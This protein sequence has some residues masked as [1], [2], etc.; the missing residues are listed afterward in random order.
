[1]TFQFGTLA[2]EESFMFAFL[3]FTL[4]FHLKPRKTYPN[5]SEISGFL[6]VVGRHRSGPFTFE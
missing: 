1:M 5:T 3:T 6:S 4:V 2:V